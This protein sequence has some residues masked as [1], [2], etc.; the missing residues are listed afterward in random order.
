MMRVAQFT[1]GLEGLYTLVKENKQ[2]AEFGECAPL[3][4]FFE[5]AVPQSEKLQELLELLKTTTFEGEPSLF[6][7][8]GAVLKAYVLLHEVKG[9]LEGAMAATGILDAYA[10]L[11]TLVKEHHDTKAGFCFPVYLRADHPSIGLTD[12][13]HPFIDPEKVVT[14]TIVLGAQERNNIILTGPN[15]GGKSTMLDLPS[16]YSWP[17]LRGLH[18]LSL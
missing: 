7:N 14:N 6:S 5:T 9:Q 1:K 4:Q 3:I 17:K 13:W 12:F 16:A 2:L 8:K 15:E 11:A 10:S 18:R